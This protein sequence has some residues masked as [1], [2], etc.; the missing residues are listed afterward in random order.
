VE[1]FLPARRYLGSGSRTY[2]DYIDE[3]TGK[4]LTAEPGGSYDIR[5]T[6]DVLPVPP[7]DGFWETP[8]TEEPAELAEPAE[9][10][11]QEE[12]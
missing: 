9:P 10:A 4:M 7:A 1:A 8:T 12:E 2:M 6:W 11:V 3:A 5:V